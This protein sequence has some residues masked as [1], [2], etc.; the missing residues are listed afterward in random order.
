MKPIRSANSAVDKH[1]NHFFGM[2][3]VDWQTQKKCA[4]NKTKKIEII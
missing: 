1:I 4:R 2:V 3:S